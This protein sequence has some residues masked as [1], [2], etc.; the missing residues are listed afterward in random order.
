MSSV[1]SSGKSPKISASV[2]PDARYSSTSETVMRRPRTQGFPLRLPDSTVMRSRSSDAITGVYD[3]FSK[4]QNPDG[5]RAAVATQSPRNS[6]DTQGASRHRHPPAAALWGRLSS[7][8]PLLARDETGR[9]VPDQHCL[10]GD[11]QQPRRV[12]KQAKKQHRI[13]HSQCMQSAAPTRTT[14]SKRPRHSLS[15]AARPFQ[16]PHGGPNDRRILAARLQIRQRPAQN[17]AHRRPTL[18]PSCSPS[19]SNCRPRR[20]PYFSKSQN[21]FRPRPHRPVLV[22]FVLDRVA[23]ITRD[24]CG[25]LVDRGSPCFL[26]ARIP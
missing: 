13:Q 25:G 24:S 3:V 2:I 5:I 10:R 16:Y 20:P 12:R 4:Q 11:R 9:R 8:Q 7:L 14:K 23:A 1:V 21:G 18:C 26:S 15:R 17:P 22:D 6:G 19:W